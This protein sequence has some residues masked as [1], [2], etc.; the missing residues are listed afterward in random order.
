MLKTARLQDNDNDKLSLLKQLSLKS[1]LVLPTDLFFLLWSEVILD[2]KGLSNLLR[3]LSLDHVSNSL[4]GKVQQ[5]LDVQVVC[6][7]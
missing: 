5:P 1:P 6:C 2:V 3:S 4:A 7:L